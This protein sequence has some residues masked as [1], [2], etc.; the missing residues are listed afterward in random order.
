MF[1]LQLIIDSDVLDILDGQDK[2]VFLIGSL[3][4]TLNVNGAVDAHSGVDVAKFWNSGQE[5][6]AVLVDVFLVGLP[7]ELG[8][9]VASLSLG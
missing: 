2:G 4:G 5:T 7:E 6:T 9:V 8:L 3:G 1:L